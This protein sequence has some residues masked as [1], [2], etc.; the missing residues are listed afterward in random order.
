MVTYIDAGRTLWCRWCGNLN[1]KS[2]QR[3]AELHAG[4]SKEEPKI[5]TPPQAPA[6]GRRTAKIKSAG[7]G[8]PTNW[9]WWGSMH[10]ISSYRG[11]RLTHKHTHPHRQIGPITIH[12]AAA[13]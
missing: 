1:E 9:V 7:D 6:R 12:C 4:C 13:S 10:A 3:D 11:N 5:F 2:T 8:Q